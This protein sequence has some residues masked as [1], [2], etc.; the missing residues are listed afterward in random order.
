MEQEIQ[1]VTLKMD[2]IE[3][4]ISIDLVREIIRVSD[5]IKV[6][7][8]PAFVEGLI[9]LRG[10]VV[11]VIDLRKRLDIPL[12][13]TNQ[14]ERVIVVEIEGRTLGILVDAVSEVLSIPAGVIDEVPPTISD[15]NMKFLSGVA[16][17][18]ERL[19]ILLDLDK[20]FSTEELMVLD[21]VK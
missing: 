11:A 5:V 9:N 15:V 19:I 17:V 18:D 2:N 10:S 7:K 12:P 21:S 14:D 13:K 16:K 1:L 4:G 3:F 6:P 8:A 20:I